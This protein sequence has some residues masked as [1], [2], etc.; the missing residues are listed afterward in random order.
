MILDKHY[1]A[2]DLSVVLLFSWYK[3]CCWLWNDVVVFVYS[4]LH[5]DF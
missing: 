4:Y 1:H 3:R 2:T 5:Y